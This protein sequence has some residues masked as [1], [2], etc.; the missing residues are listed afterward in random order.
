MS[1]NRLL[2][3]SCLVVSVPS[4]AVVFSA[5]PGCEVEIPGEG[6]P[7]VSANWTGE[8]KDGKAVG[9]GKLSA[10]W[11]NGRKSSYEGHLRQG[12]FGGEGKYTSSTG[13]QY[14]GTFKDGVPEG[15]G[16]LSE[17]D[18]VYYG[19]FKAGQ[20]YDGKIEVDGKLTS[21]RVTSG[22]RTEEFDISQPQ[23]DKPAS[24]KETATP[25]T[26]AKV[27]RPEK[28]NSGSGGKYPGLTFYI[29]IA[30]DKKTYATY[31]HSEGEAR[32]I[33]KSDAGRDTESIISCGSGVWARW[34]YEN[35]RGDE[36]AVGVTCQHRS[37]ES[38]IKQALE[39]CERQGRNCREGPNEPSWSVTVVAGKAFEKDV[40]VGRMYDWTDHSC[41]FARGEVNNECPIIDIL[42]SMGINLH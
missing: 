7:P 21:A 37:Y 29:V 15:R 42:R 13:Y 41:E 3:F 22:V 17:G 35:G 4:F 11:S 33:V 10:R 30:A 16:L 12:K 40:E 9:T 6:V 20:L 39:A 23:P 5:G 38:A 24:S 26:S 27:A 31:A 25:S 8:C 34:T 28:D 14:R 32:D 18:V 1:F 19:I 36:R 2:F